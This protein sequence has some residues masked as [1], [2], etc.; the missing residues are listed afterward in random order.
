VLFIVFG[1]VIYSQPT[2]ICISALVLYLGCNAVSFML[3]PASIAKGIVIKGFIIYGLI[4]AVRAALA[5]Q[6]PPT[7]E[8]T[9]EPAA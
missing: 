5:Y 4:R 1:I 3:D 2:I 7:V 6:Q 9:P 8:P